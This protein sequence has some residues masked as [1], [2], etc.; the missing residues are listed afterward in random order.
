[1]LHSLTDRAWL[2]INKVVLMGKLICFVSVVNECRKVLSA[3]GFKEL[4]EKEHWDI[5]PSDKVRNKSWGFFLNFGKVVVW[6]WPRI[7]GW[8]PEIKTL[9][10]GKSQGA[11][12]IGHTC[13]LW[14]EWGTRLYFCRGG[15]E[16][17]VQDNNILSFPPPPPHPPGHVNSKWPSSFIKNLRDAPP[18]PVTSCLLLIAY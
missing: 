18:S 9:L 8:F 7:S 2:F 14:N 6:T 1:M 4:K 13:F 12:K 16:K 11:L 5:K 17:Y 10:S 15:R 3:A